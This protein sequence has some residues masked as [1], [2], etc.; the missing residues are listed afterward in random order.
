MRVLRKTGVTVLGWVLLVVGVVALIL[1]GPGLLMLVA[2]LVILSQEYDW[3]ERRVEPI[4]VKAFEV[5]ASG[6][7]TWPRILASIACAL[8]VIAVG[9]LWWVDPEIPEFWILGPQLPAGGWG[10]GLSI[11]VS[12]VIALSLIAYS[13]RRFR[14]PADDQAA[15]EAT[16]AGQD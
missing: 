10:A 11:I 6:V 8:V 16:Y 12:G 2:G 9:A 13:V 7:R 1:P 4:K 14:G 15:A 5:A 3:A